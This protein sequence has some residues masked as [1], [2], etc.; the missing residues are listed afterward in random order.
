MKCEQCG[1]RL[2][3]DDKIGESHG[4]GLYV[5]IDH[6]YQCPDCGHMR[7]Y[8]GEPKDHERGMAFFRR[9]ADEV[10]VYLRPFCD[11]CGAPMTVTKLWPLEYS[12]TVQWKCDP[13]RRDCDDEYLIAETEPDE[14]L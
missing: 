8:R 14:R 2:T 7:H 4:V 13:E 12:E 1:T 6:M 10:L 9:T 5:H 11:T 3:A